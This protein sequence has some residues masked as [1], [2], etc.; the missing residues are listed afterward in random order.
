[1]SENR[2]RFN[3]F[4]VPGLFA[5]A[6]ESFKRHTPTW[7]D[8]YTVRSTT[9]AYEESAF[10]SGLG[11]LFAKPEGTPFT[12]DERIQGFSKVWNMTAYAMSLKMTHEQI[13]DD[14]YG[15]MKMGAKDLGI[16]AAAS[17]HLLAVR[18]LMN[19]TATTYHTCGD[20]LAW[21]VSNHTRLDG[22]TWSNVMAAA[23]PTTASVE[24]AVKNFE[25]IVDHRGKNYDQ[26]VKSIVCGPTHE[27]T[28]A[29][30]LDSVQVAENA[31]NADNTLKS[32]RSIMLKIEPEITDGRWF[33][34]GDKNPDTG[35][36]HFDREK[37][38][39]QRHGNPDTGDS[40]FTI[41][42]RFSNECNEPRQIYMV[43]AT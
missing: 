23:T 43:P 4:Y 35:L 19:A 17:I 28:M 3:K 1:M 31:N 9:K 27:F 5:A 37:P 38:V 15:L 21:C 33:V 24:A 10:M 13:E 29:K 22:S 30:I 7:K 39:V 32:R 26:K 18:P 20:G 42:T 2:A 6:S 16:S 34:M 40:I 41:Y 14:Q 8:Y 11:Y 25:A 36:I 12:E